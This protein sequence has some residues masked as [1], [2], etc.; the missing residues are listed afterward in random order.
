MEYRRCQPPCSRFIANDDPHSKCVNSMDFSHA[1][2]AVYRISK[3]KFCENVRLKILRSRLAVFERES[4]VFP[5]HALEAS[6]AFLESATWGSDVELEA[7]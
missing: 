1:H 3:Y 5:R 7:I 2:E 4:F 6:A